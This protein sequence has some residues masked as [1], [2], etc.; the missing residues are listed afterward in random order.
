VLPKPTLYQLSHLY[1]LPPIA[2]IISI[3]APDL[4]VT[5]RQPFYKAVA[6]AFSSLSVSLL[7]LGNLDYLLYSHSLLSALV[8]VSLGLGFVSGL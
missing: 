3:A 4:C 2:L 5:C 7:R 8:S 6:S 1:N